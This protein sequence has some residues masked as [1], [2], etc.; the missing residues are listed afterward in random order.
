MLTGLLCG[1]LRKAKVSA[2]LWHVMHQ[3]ERDAHC[4]DVMG[5]ANLE[6]ISESHDSRIPSSDISRLY[7][8]V[9]TEMESNVDFREIWMTCN[10]K[11]SCKQQTQP[12][13]SKARVTLAHSFINNHGGS[14]SVD[15]VSGSKYNHCFLFSEKTIKIRDN[16]RCVK[17]VTKWYVVSPWITGIWVFT[18]SIQHKLLSLTCENVGLGYLPLCSLSL[19]S[20]ASADLIGQALFI[21]LRPEMQKLHLLPFLHHLSPSTDLFVPISA[22]PQT[23][24]FHWSKMIPIH[25]VTLSFTHSTAGNSQLFT[26][27]HKAYTAQQGLSLRHPLASS[28]FFAQATQPVFSPKDPWRLF[29][30]Q[31]DA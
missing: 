22:W 11:F 23:Y 26:M 2:H 28:L 25:C 4:C 1:P 9:H 8:V 19:L 20:H 15:F 6:N 13:F 16:S 31:V 5:T 14:Q 29:P 3:Q 12:W 21:S 10:I 24:F 30:I 18:I 7:I 17:R 27:T